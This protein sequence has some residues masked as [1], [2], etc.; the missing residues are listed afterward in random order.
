MQDVAF[1]AAA[2]IHHSVLQYLGSGQ[3]T[4]FAKPTAGYRPLL[5]MSFFRRLALKSVMAAER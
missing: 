2:T 3:V 1:I 5:M 4:P